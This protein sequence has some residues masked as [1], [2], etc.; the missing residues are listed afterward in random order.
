[1]KS[2]TKYK[3]MS[4][5]QLAE[6][7]EFRRLH[8]EGQPGFELEVQLINAMEAKDWTYED[9]AK[10]VGT[11]KSNI[12]RDLN[13]GINSATVSRLVKI[14]DA[15]GLRFVP[16]FILKNAEK[17]AVPKLRKLVAA[18]APVNHNGTVI[19]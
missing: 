19:E 12:S 13:G 14:A 1:M 4:E 10:A 7:P 17:E 8:E 11:Q 6:D 5:K 15:L 18:Y 16:L 9:L 3:S 2:T